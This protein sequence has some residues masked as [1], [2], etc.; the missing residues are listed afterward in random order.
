MRFHVSLDVFQGPLDLLLY[1]VRKHELEATELALAQ[2]TEQYLEHLAVIEHLDVNAAGD[3]LGIASTL[4]EIKSRQALPRTEDPEEE[5]EDPCHDLVRRLLEDKEYR[6]AA[7]MLAERGRQWRDRFP[8]L[9]T[10]PAPPKPTAVNQPLAGVELWDLVSALGRVMQ[11]KFGE[12]PATNVRYD[13]TP[14]HVYMRQIYERVMQERQVAFANV[15]E[16]ADHRS[17]RVGM[18]LAV[19]ELTRHDWARAYQ[20]ELFGEIVLTLG[21]NPLP[22]DL[23]HVAEYDAQQRT[24]A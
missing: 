22:E 9:A 19:L 3:F 6:D 16:G 21:E 8:R 10:E 13:E 17:A 12:S 5:T 23:D 7:S 11:S 18:F 4:I 1:L 20:R 2:V 14:I 24:A 15:L